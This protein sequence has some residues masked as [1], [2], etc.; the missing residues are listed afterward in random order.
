[1]EVISR[2]KIIYTKPTPQ[3]SPHLPLLAT[4]SFLFPLAKTP[5]RGSNCPTYALFFRHH[6]NSIAKTP[7]YSLF[8]QP[9]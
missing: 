5:H 2:E 9:A 6:V 4:I 1:M 8:H 7:R 3:N